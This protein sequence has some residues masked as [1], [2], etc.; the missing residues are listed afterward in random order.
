[1]KKCGAGFQPAPHDCCGQV[2]NLPH[3]FF[4]EAQMSKLA[5]T[6]AL[7]LLLC[8]CYA[9]AQVAQTALEGDWIG[10]WQVRGGWVSAK[11]QFNYD[12]GT[13]GG[14]I[15][16]QQ[17]YG[18]TQKLALTKV[19]LEG[20]R[21]RL[22]ASQDA[23]TPAPA[24]ALALALDGQLKG[25]VIAGNFLQGEAQ[26]RF[27]LLRVARVDT[28]LFDQY[29]GS[30]RVAPDNFISIGRQTRT[31]Q[32]PRLGYVERKSGRRG[33]LTPISET[34]FI[35]GPALGLDYPADVEITFVRNKQGVVEGLKWR[36]EKAAE[37]FATNMKLKEEE[38]RFRNGEI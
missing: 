12:K 26:G 10:G 14:S 13:L 6:S 24:L 16:L 30:Y 22:E 8:F 18:V 38:V 27:E 37:R 31:G 19:A 3:T 35:G 1:M 9:P 11:A 36:R 28:K 23:A 7:S 4:G 2:G 20:A 17:L 34:A 33:N 21:L 32:N 25:D 5:V 15:D 29:V